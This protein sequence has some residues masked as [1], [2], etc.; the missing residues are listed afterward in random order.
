MKSKLSTLGF[1]L[2]LSAL[3]VSG[4]GPTTAQPAPV[5]STPT[6]VPP[7]PVPPMPTPS[8][9]VEDLIGVWNR[10]CMYLQF[11]ED[12]TFRQGGSPDRLEEYPSE[13]GTFQLDGTSL[14]LITSEDSFLCSGQTGSFEV[15]LTQQGQLKLMLREDECRARGSGMSR[16]LWTRVSPTGA[17]VSPTPAATESAVTFPVTVTEDAVYAVALQPDVSPPEWRLDVYAP[18]EPGPWPV[19]VFAHGLGDRKENNAILSRSI[20]EQGAVVFTIGYPTMDPSVAITDNGRGFREMLDT[21][22]CAIRFARARA[23]DNGG[24]AA[25]V[26]LVGFSLGGGA[27]AHIALVGDDLDRRWEEFVSL[28]GGPPRQVECEVSGG[29]AHVD[30]FVGV[31]GAYDAFVGTDGKYGREWL[32]DKD[33]ELWEM[34]NSS[35]GENLDLKVRLIHG[36]HDSTIPFE[37]SVEFDTALAEAGYDTVLIPHDGYHEIPTELTVQTVMEVARD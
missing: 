3:I 37:N 26:T 8:I 29:S 13:V 21:L 35:L 23:P 22:A 16:G 27:G 31:A 17:P 20:A 7:T 24:D 34:L 36:E 11:R 28:R 12:G 25:R 2:I 4:C 14:T 5:P 19:V 32:Q 1:V 18:T 33:P 9:T 30:A 6:A 15:E 10:A